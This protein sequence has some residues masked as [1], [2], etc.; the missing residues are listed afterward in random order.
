MG[1]CH[2]SVQPSRQLF[3]AFGPLSS[4]SPET[5]PSP[6]VHRHLYFPPCEV[7]LCARDAPPAK[8]KR[9]SAAALQMCGRSKTTM[10]PAAVIREKI[11]GPHRAVAGRCAR[12]PTFGRRSP[13]CEGSLLRSLQSGPRSKDD[14]DIGFIMQQGDPLAAMCQ[15]SGTVQ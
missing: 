5:E 6:W 4:I 2:R 7:V 13:E 9:S 15:T 3:V 1:A 10:T 11:N 8:E 12:H 14:F